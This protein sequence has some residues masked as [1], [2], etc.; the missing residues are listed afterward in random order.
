MYIGHPQKIGH[1]WKIH[2][3][4]KYFVIIPPS[5]VKSSGRATD[6]VQTSTAVFVCLSLFE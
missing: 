4:S 2:K 6:P 3:L 1:R 5:L